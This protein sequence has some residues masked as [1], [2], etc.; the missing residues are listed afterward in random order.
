MMFRLI[1][2]MVWHDGTATS[3]GGVGVVVVTHNDADIWR[4]VQSTVRLHV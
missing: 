3:V 2:G 1:V 4:Q